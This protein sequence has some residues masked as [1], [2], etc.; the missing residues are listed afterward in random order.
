MVYSLGAEF[1]PAT[2][3]GMIS[4]SA[5][6][7]AGSEMGEIDAL[8]E[9]IKDAIEGIPEIEIVFSSAGGGQMYGMGSSSAGSMTVLLKNL[10]E[11][12]KSAK[13][14]S[15]EIRTLTK[16]IPG[17]EISVS[18]TSTM[19]MGMTMGAISITIKGDD[20]DTLKTIGD[21]FKRIIERVEGTRE[22]TTSYEDGI[23][24]VQVI[25]DRAIASQYGL[26]TAQIGG[27]IASALSGSKATTY[28]VNGDE[29]VVIKE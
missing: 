22:V 15:D 8:L 12:D 25:T 13:E 11:R 23:P 24:Q 27:S 2:D 9:E 3:E 10:D 21:D 1:F 29:M 14:I 26:T 7:P 5:D 28:K 19:M 6:L 18:E 20:M 4:I 16:D 17:A